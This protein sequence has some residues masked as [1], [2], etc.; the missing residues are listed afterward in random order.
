MQV[1]FNYPFSSNRFGSEI[2]P[3]IWVSPE[4]WANNDREAKGNGGHRLPPLHAHVDRNLA[5]LKTM[6]IGVVRWF[7]LGNGNSYRPGSHAPE[8]CPLAQ[9]RVE[10][11]RSVIDKRFRRDFT[12]LL[13]VSRRQACS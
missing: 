13:S 6:G 7:L 4:V 1:G 2:G 5:L 8:R 11:T 3:N 10:Y 9:L 12:A